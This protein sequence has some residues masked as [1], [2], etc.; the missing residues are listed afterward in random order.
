MPIFIF[1]H[2]LTMFAAV[3][4]AYGPTALM[5]VASR[6]G[7][8]R[9]LR[10]ITGIYNKLGER[11][12]GPAFGIGI[13]FG[14]IAVFVH[15]FDPRLGWLVIAYLLVGAALVMTFRFTGPWLAKVQAAAEASPDDRMSPELNE[16]VNSRRNQVMLVVDALIIVAL[17]ADMV[18][19][20]LPNRLF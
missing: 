8:V 11:V 16:L 9:A 7:D 14:F 1:L 19:K 18:L 2:V 5:V 20:P 3:A 13:V 15:G 12:I 10:S 4:L 17:I 6:N